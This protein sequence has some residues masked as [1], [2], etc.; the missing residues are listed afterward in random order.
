MHAG[1]CISINSFA[2]QTINLVKEYDGRRV[3]SSPAM[4]DVQYDEVL[5]NLADCTS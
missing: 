2:S 4:Q 3:L 1:S 5:K